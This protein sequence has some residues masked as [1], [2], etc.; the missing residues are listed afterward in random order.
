M[1]VQWPKEVELWKMY[2]NGR[3]RKKD[4]RKKQRR[5]R[6]S[7]RALMERDAANDYKAMVEHMRSIREEG[8]EV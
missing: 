8:G 6:N 3:S 4:R 2:Q 7:H 1:T 5:R